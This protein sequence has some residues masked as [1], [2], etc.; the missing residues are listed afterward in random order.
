[1]TD[2]TCI[3]CGR[4]A[5]GGH[6]HW[7]TVPLREGHAIVTVRSTN[8][9]AHLCFVCGM[10]VLASPKLTEAA[11]DALAAHGRKIEQP[12]GPV[13]QIVAAAIEKV[14]AGPKGPYREAV[15]EALDALY[16]GSKGAEPRVTAE[17]ALAELRG[18]AEGVLS[19]ETNGLDV[20]ALTLRV[21]ILAQQHG[22]KLRE[23]RR[24][25]TFNPMIEPEIGGGS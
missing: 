13:Q 19:M 11:T 9:E 17:Q 18:F 20:Q 2:N 3:N 24:R 12:K 10:S 25:P 6:T 1:M 21:Q 23:P 22:I 14:K 7:R 15:E 4:P 8:A 16:G 5:D